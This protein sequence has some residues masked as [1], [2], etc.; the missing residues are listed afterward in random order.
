[1]LFLLNALCTNTV[2]TQNKVRIRNDT[3]Y[4]ADCIQIKEQKIFYT[5]TIARTSFKFTQGLVEP[6]SP[7][8][9]ISVLVCVRDGLFIVQNSFEE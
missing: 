2:N 4:M 1:M 6:V 3:L 8:V 9:E 5:I 7:L